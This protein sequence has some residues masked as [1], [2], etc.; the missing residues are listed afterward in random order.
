MNALCQTILDDIS[1]KDYQ[2]LSSKRI[3]KI[4]DQTIQDVDD[5][6]LL[7]VKVKGIDRS[8]LEQPGWLQYY[9]IQGAEIHAAVECI[10]LEIDIRKSQLWKKLTEE[11][12]RDLSQMDKTNYL[13]HDEIIIWL[14]RFLYVLNEVRQKFL[15]IV[16]AFRAQGYSLN[17]YI[18][19]KQGAVDID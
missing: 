18:R 15:A 10:E 13:G 3:I 2:F 11:H 12:S 14:K 17:S 19:A 8:V 4:Y 6:K 1:K 9:A 5:D 16:D 7:N